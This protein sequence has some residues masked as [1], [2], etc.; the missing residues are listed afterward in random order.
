MITEYAGRVRFENVEEGVTVT[1]QTDEITGL[2]TLVV[3]DGKRRTST[4][5]LLRP[6]VKLLDENG[7]EV[8]V[9]GTETPV[10]MAFPVGAVITVREDQEGARATCWRVY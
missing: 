7:E 2:S 8:T 6:T 10:S 1:R 3:I 4:S 5:K 9:P